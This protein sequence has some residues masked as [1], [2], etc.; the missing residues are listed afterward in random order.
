LTADI[1]AAGVATAIAAATCQSLTG[2]GFALVMTPLMALAWDTKQ[3]VALS[4]LLSPVSVAIMLPEVHGHIPFG[5]VAV[6][7]VGFLVGMPV[8]AF[9]LYE[10][11]ADVLRAAIAAVVII[12]A[13]ALY[14]GPSLSGTN[15][16]FLARLLAGIGVGSI[17]SSTSMGGPPLV[18]YL[19][20][21]EH[22]VNSFRA[23]TLALFLPTSLI[24]FAAAA[25]VGVVTSDVLLLA[26]LCIPAVLFGLWIGRAARGRLDPQRFRALVLAVL[27]LTGAA[28]LASSTA[29]WLA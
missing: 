15:D 8:G 2:F 25:V 9:L 19:V 29:N 27:V 23:T 6:L 17:G 20:P 4:L 1:I 16:G 13:G 21:R 28:V 26:A 24:S 3:A 14:F 5:R 10:L 11:D 18:L 7:F 22:D 12:A